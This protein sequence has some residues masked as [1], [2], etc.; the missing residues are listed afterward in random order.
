MAALLAP[1]MATRIQIRVLRFNGWAGQA[2]AT[3]ARAK[4]RAK[5][6]W[7]KRMKRPKS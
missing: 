5:T 7:E 3:E 6:V 1:T 4:G 2:K